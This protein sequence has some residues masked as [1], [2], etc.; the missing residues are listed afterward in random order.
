MSSTSINSLKEEKS[1][2][3][4]IKYKLTPPE[5]GWGYIVAVAV[6]V[7]VNVTAQPQC[8]FGLIFGNFLADIGDETT[9]TTLA[10]GMFNTVFSFTGLLSNILL[11]KYSHRTVGILG[12]TIFITGQF[13]TIFVTNL[14]QMVLFFGV[15]QGIGFGLLLPAV[16]SS[17]N[18]YFEKRINVMMGLCQSF[19]AAMNI[20]VPIMAKLCMDT[21]GFRASVALLAALS[22]NC[23]PGVLSLQPVKRHLKKIPILEH[24]ENKYLRIDDVKTKSVS[25]NDL[26]TKDQMQPLMEEGLNESNIRLYQKYLATKPRP[27]IASLGERF[28]SISS[29]GEMERTL[30][31]YTLNTEDQPKQKLFDLSLFKDPK[32]INISIGMSLSF[33]SDLAFISILPMVLTGKNFTSSEIAVLI[34]VLFVSDFTSRILLSAVSTVLAIKNRHIFLLGTTLSAAFRCGFLMSNGYMWTMVMCS[35]LGFLR[36]LIQTPLPLVITEEYPSNFSTAF[37]FYMV[38]CGVISLIFGPLMSYIKAVTG[39]DAMV[40]HVLTLAYLICTVTWTIEMIL[41]KLKTKKTTE[42]TG[43]KG[44]N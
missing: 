21:Y 6:T 17:L 22:L 34:S 38:I 20:V 24:I 4:E 3:N 41:S 16:Y 25:L 30:S 9:G 10:N 26:A 40:I 18:T 29:T 7:I 11:Q 44:A 14:I 23:L 43:N 5:G 2:K 31:K 39:S 15:I 19:M 28:L 36:C 35:C 13:A 12:A 42:T 33:T 37:S 32:F 27:S 1:V 8:A